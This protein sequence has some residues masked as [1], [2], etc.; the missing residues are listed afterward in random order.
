ME[1]ACKRAPP[2]D[3]TK[4][5]FGLSNHTLFPL[6]ERYENYKEYSEKFMLPLLLHETWESVSVLHVCARNVTRTQH[7][8]PVIPLLLDIHV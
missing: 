3:V 7:F 5:L 4:D 2:P 8:R 1:Q 6:L